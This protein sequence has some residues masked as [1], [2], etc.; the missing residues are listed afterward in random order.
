MLILSIPQL[1]LSLLGKQKTS[2]WKVFMT[3]RVGGI[4]P[5]SSAWKADIIATIRH[6]LFAS[7]RRGRPAQRNFYNSYQYT[8]IIFFVQTSAKS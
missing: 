3:E 7:L 1:D 2:Q 8:R 5:P 4:E 6:P